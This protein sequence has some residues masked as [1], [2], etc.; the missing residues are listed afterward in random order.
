MLHSTV[1][2]GRRTVILQ[3]SLTG[4]TSQH[5]SFS[6]T[7]PSINIIDAVGSTPKLA[8]HKDKTAAVL[9][10]WPTAA[11]ASV[12]LCEQPPIPFGMGAGTITYRDNGTVQHVGFPAGRPCVILAPRRERLAV[13]LSFSQLSR[14]QQKLSVT[15][16]N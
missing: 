16:G 14:S 9:Q 13:L 4:L 10:M 7:S 12:C 1:A 2:A 6:V 3:R 5:Y 15:A 8:Y 11:A